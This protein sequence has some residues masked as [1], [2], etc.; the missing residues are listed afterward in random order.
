MTWGHYCGSYC[1]LT[2][3]THHGSRCC[4]HTD[5]WSPRECKILRNGPGSRS[6]SSSRSQ[7]ISDTNIII[8][9]IIL[10][11]TTLLLMGGPRLKS[12]KSS[13]TWQTLEEILAK[14]YLQVLSEETVRLPGQPGLWR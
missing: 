4:N 1:G 13:L 5:V 14:E 10:L 12:R 7:N 11:L 2:V 8:I 9:I 3:V 6:L